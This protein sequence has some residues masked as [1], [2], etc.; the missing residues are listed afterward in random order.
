MS[1]S[2][3]DRGVRNSQKSYRA[4]WLV[5]ALAA[6]AI[7]GLPAQAGDRDRERS[8]RCALIDEI[9]FDHGPVANRTVS[10]D[11]IVPSQLQGLIRTDRDSLT[12]VWIADIDL[13]TNVNP[14]ACSIPRAEDCSGALEGAC[15]GPTAPP[16]SPIFQCE[17]TILWTNNTFAL[18][19]L[20]TGSLYGLNM[21]RIWDQ[22]AFPT[23]GALRRNRPPALADGYVF[24]N[25]VRNEDG[26]ILMT[27]SVGEVVL[28][29]QSTG[30]HP[31]LADRIS[32]A[33]RIYDSNV[34]RVI[35]SNAATDTALSLIYAP[36]SPR[37]AVWK[38][39]L[40]RAPSCVQGDEF[41][42]LVFPPRRAIRIEVDD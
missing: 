9:Q 3:Y 8:S 15:P 10:L 23:I 20:T 30:A 32:M 29:G 13:F 34:G 40:R 35:L 27:S 19:E 28:T 22:G 18:Y 31:Q 36:N 1:C 42:R 26:T 16:D 6:L 39:N 5:V 7:S 37:E 33:G 17:E 14:E 38:I 41:S 12:G 24:Q 11:A 4:R 25:G 21:W 2:K